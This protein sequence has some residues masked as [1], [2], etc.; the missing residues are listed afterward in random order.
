MTADQ[1]K[2]LKE[3]LNKDNGEGKT[4]ATSVFYDFDNG[5][6]FRNNNEF[7]IFDDTNELIHC[8]A[9]NRNTRTKDETAYCMY[10]AAYEQLQFT[11]ANLTL[12]GLQAILDNMLSSLITEDQKQHII[13]WAT[14]LPCNPISTVVS[15]Y[16][17]DPNPTIPYRPVTVITRPDGVSN[18][19]PV[20]GNT[21]S[22]IIKTTTVK[23]A[24]TSI[25]NASDGDSI[26]VSNKNNEPI[27]EALTVSANNVTITGT[28]LELNGDTV[29]DGDG[30]TMNGIVFGNE[31]VTGDYKSSHLL[32]LN[33]N[34]A[35]LTGC[36]FKDDGTADKTRTAIA[37][38]SRVVTIEDCV[39]DG[40]GGI[41]NAFESNYNTAT[42]EKFVFRN[43]VFKPEAAS[44]N[45]VSMYKFVDG[46]QVLFENCSF[47]F[48]GDSNAIRLSNLDNTHA[49]IIFKDCKMKST[50]DGTYAGFLLLQDP[51][52]DKSED[53]S[54][55]T[56]NFINFTNFE[57]KVYKDNNGTGVDKIWYTYNSDTEPVVNFS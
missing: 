47:E 3:Q 13:D 32:A 37:A 25:G 49:T 7:V 2:Y 22:E 43:C 57:G 4:T 29:I 38:A 51:T 8:I 15:T 23:N 26:V 30:V 34:N 20:N 6:A 17:K 55:F 27:T 40:A 18:G 24:V 33:G 9:A 42:I 11:E 46:A 10:S 45:F 19:Y 56:I 12:E 53:F 52:S 41:Y 21:D 35:T 1:V 5:M 31:N 54:L 44:N 50:N 48:G 28:N 36:T 16:H 14:T 39:F